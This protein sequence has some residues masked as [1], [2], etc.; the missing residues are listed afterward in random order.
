MAHLIDH[1]GRVKLV[2]SQD[3][4]VAAWEATDDPGVFL[5][6]AS[7]AAPGTK[8]RADFVCDGVNDHLIWQEAVDSLPSW[9]GRVLGSEG[10]FLFSG[11]V[12]LP[13]K[14]VTI[15]GL[16]RVVTE[17]YMA[18]SAN[19]GAFV[20]VGQHST[21]RS[22]SLNGNR[23]N[24]TGSSSL[25]KLTNTKQ[26]VEDLWV[27]SAKGH[28][29]EI[30]G[31]VS[32]PAHANKVRGVYI[33]DCGL[34]GLNV[35]STYS[36]DTQVSDLWSGQNLQHG[37][38]VASVECEFDNC[39]SWGNSTDGLRITAVTGTRV[40]GGYYETNTGRG[41]R[42][43]GSSHRTL[44][45]GAHL[46][47]NVSNGIYGFSSNHW[48]I[49][50]CSVEENGFGTGGVP[51]IVI[52]TG[53]YWTVS[54]NIFYDAQA[55]KTQTYAMGD[56]GGADYVAFVGNVARSADHKTGDIN[57]TGLNKVVKSNIGPTDS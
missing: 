36:Y 4:V 10:Q 3:V 29:I 20:L 30:L 8:A 5:V 18:N 38:Q 46:R 45:S 49:M 53:N 50:G 28:G 43:A 17:I 39:H 9:G 1:E 56:A 41:I 34:D 47:R 22:M 11:V 31:T 54:G 19:S 44:I 16:G 7:D 23:T 26:V 33:I 42:A 21:I 27:T 35:G 32:V 12:T 48:T 2:S 6:A 55:T 40:H 37:I 13:N 51:G 24:Q 14:P 57:L 15:E 25:V 52:D